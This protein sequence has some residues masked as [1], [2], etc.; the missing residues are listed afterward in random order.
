M[1]PIFAASSR[2]APSSTAA[3]ANPSRLRSVFR[4][5]GKSA[6]LAGGIVRPHRNSVAH[7]KP[8]QFATLNHAAVDSGIPRE[9]ATQRLGITHPAGISAARRRGDRMKRREFITLL[10]GA[11]AW[12]LTARAAGPA[13][14]ADRRADG[15][16]G[17]RSGS[18]IRARSVRPRA[19][20]IGLVRRPQFADRYSLGEPRRSGVDAS[21]REG[22]RRVTARPHSFAQHCVARGAHVASP[23]VERLK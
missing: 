21:I 5:L 2:E 17:E 10:G 16:A 15:L 1:P 7:G 9:S 14:A 18:P 23:T 19:S 4:S 8:P 12:P 11:A 22:T 20:E 6:N 3:I 13:D